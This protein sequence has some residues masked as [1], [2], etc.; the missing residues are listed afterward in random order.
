M[1]FT[2]GELLGAAVRGAKTE[3][4]V[5]GINADSRAVGKGE[6]FFALPGVK[7]HGDSFSADAVARGA[8]AIV[9]D[10]KPKADPG[11]PVTGERL[12]T[13]R[14]EAHRHGRTRLPGVR[15]WPCTA[16]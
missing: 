3:I 1:A 15:R 10:R 14:P 5:S 16:S 7:V 6:A 9:S 4:R 11:V 8:V 13:V 12:R 2:L